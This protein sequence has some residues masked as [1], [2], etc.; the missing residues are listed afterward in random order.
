GPSEHETAEEALEQFFSDGSIARGETWEGEIGGV[1]MR[2]ASFALGQSPHR[3]AGLIAYADFRERVL[4]MIAI[5]PETDWIERAEAIATAFS[6]FRVLKDPALL[7]VEPMRVR[8][9]ELGGSTTLDEL[10]RSHP[11]VV[12]VQRLERLNRVKAGDALPA[13]HRVKRVE[14]TDPDDPRIAMP[15]R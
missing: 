9:M 2:S 1:P 7:R 10:Q 6:S 3:I 5:G 14:G 11:S 8:V 4:V 12:A 15:G 13:G